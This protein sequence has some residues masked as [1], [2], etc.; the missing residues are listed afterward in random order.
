MTKTKL[1]TQESLVDNILTQFY[2][3]LGTSQLKG[4]HNALYPLM[5]LVEQFNVSGPDKKSIVMSALRNLNLSYINLDEIQRFVAEEADDLI[6]DM[7]RISK[8]LHTQSKRFFRC[9][10]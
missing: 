4:V 7:V 9:L 10:N 8:T 5:S 1:I 6:E 3:L 2:N